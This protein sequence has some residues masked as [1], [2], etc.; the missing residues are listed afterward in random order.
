MSGA[1]RPGIYEGWAL[2]NVRPATE[3]VLE[4]ILFSYSNPQLKPSP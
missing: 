2:K 1:Q 4:T 3:H